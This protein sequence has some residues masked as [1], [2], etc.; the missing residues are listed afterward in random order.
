MDDLAVARGAIHGFVVERSDRESYSPV[1]ESDTVGFE[2]IDGG[3]LG[4]IGGTSWAHRPASGG[5]PA[6]SRLAF[7]DMAG[8][9]G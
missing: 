4:R 2:E 6:C 3:G 1:A 5:F 7:T 8:P 9:V